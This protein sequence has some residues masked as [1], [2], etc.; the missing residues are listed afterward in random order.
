MCEMKLRIRRIRHSVSLLVLACATASAG[1][2][3]GRLPDLNLC[4]GSP[5]HKKRIPIK[6]VAKPP[7]MKYYRDPGFSSKV[8]RVTNS[9]KNEVHKPPYSTMQAWNADESLLLLYRTSEQSSSHVLLD[10]FTYEKIR[11][12]PISSSDLEEVFWSHTDP[13]AFYYVSDHYSD[14]GE[15]KKF[16]VARNSSEKITDFKDICGDK[17]MPVAGNDVHMQSL[18]DDLFGF[19]CNVGD[20]WMAF[21]YRI[22]TDETHSIKLDEASGWDAWSA[23]MPGPDGK[24]VW[25]Q[26]YAMNPELTV[27][28]SKLDVAKDD[29][30]SNIGQTHDGKNALFQTVFD[31]SPNGCDGSRDGGVGH[32]VV[33]ELET[34]SCR[35]MIN[36][37]NGYPYTT[38]GTHVSAQAYR[39]PGWVAMSSIGR[40]DQFDFFTIGL[41]APVLLSEIYLAN[42]DPDNQTVCR[43]AQHRSF[44]KHAQNGTY[45]SYFGEPHATISPSGTRII[46][47]SDWYDSGSV[48]SYVIELPMYKRP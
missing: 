13:N 23:P 31:P 15:F 9:S 19:R 12:L 2:L 48:D 30:H 20:D 8:I 38:S 47:G 37:L 1:P 21:T 36:E 35:P 24:Q 3:P 40:S 34:A 11:D 46:F 39:R 43:L 18:D 14:L 42:T 26:G 29:E 4:E 25:F 27:K 45:N 5:S 33:H 10:G 41:R 6:A 22:S 32:L 16:N 7:F 17:G 44:G 28:Q